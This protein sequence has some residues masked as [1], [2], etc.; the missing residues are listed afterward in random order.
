MDR[1]PRGH[2]HEHDTGFRLGRG[3]RLHAYDDCNGIGLWYHDDSVTYD[4]HFDVNCPLQ[5]C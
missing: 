2:M 5:I 3:C 1:R 4:L